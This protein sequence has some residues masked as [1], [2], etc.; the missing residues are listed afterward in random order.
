MLTI[1]NNTRVMTDLVDLACFINRNLDRSPDQVLAMIREKF[2]E[3][4]PAEI[5]TAVGGADDPDF[6]R[7][8]LR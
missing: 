1:S 3:V 4:T 7:R 5:A 8:H 2:P 6:N